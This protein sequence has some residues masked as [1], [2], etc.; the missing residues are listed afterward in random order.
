ML[1]DSFTKILKN[2]PL[3]CT[4]N[5]IIMDDNGKPIDYIF[6]ESNPAFDQMLGKEPGSVQGKKVSEVAPEVFAPARQALRRLHRGRLLAHRS[7]R[8]R[9]PPRPAR[10]EAPAILMRSYPAA[11]QGFC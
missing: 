4:Y 10:P 9:F 5:R 11:C 3:G 7:G 2:S 8:A 1:N 6:L